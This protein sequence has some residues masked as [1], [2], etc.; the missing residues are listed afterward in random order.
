MGLKTDEKFKALND[1]GVEGP[2]FSIVFHGVKDQES[3]KSNLESTTSTLKEILLDLGQDFEEA[4][5]QIKFNV[6][7]KDDVCA[8]EVNLSECQFIFPFISSF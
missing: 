1:V 3:L 4:L 7:Q 8:L 2:S 5:N 6:K